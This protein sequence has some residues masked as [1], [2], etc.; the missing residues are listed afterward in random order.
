MRGLVQAIPAVIWDSGLRRRR[1]RRTW[2]GRRRLIE[3]GWMLV[4]YYPA[5]YI[6]GALPAFELYEW[7]EVK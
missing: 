6:Y 2:Y 1:L 4:R 5:L 3:E 7:R